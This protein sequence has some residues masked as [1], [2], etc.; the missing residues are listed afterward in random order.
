MYGRLIKKNVSEYPHIKNVYCLVL[1]T[2]VHAEYGGIFLGY[3]R[4][5]CPAD[6]TVGPILV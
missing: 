1:F 3:Q 4:R 5:I 2:H 6:G